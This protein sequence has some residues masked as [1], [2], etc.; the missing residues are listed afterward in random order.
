LK[1]GIG[2]LYEYLDL[3]YYLETLGAT[4]SASWKIRSNETAFSGVSYGFTDGIAKLR[5]M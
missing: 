5:L 3:L 2:E 1:S 4:F